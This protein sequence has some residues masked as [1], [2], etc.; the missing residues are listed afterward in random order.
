[1]T[2]S[3]VIHSSR[4]LLLGGL[5]AASVTACDDPFSPYWDRGTYYL[6]SA[7]NRYVPAV[8]SQ[9]PGTSYLEVRSGSLTLRRDHSYQLVVELREQRAGTIYEYSAVFAGPYESEHRTL[10]LSYE[11][12]RGNWRNV[13][14]NWRDG[15]VELVVPEIDNGYGV[16][17]T[18]SDW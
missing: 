17:C 11:D 18:F 9:G 1:M 5:L 3:S 13:V 6:K 10:Y 8:V 7:N 15:K 12:D 2:L 16:L 14:A 4:K